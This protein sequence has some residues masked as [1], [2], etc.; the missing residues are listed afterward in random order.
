MTC[1]FLQIQ[2]NKMIGLNFHDFVLHAM[3]Y[4]CTVPV[5]WFQSSFQQPKVYLVCTV[6]S[7]KNNKR[8]LS[9][10]RWT[11]YRNLTACVYFTFFKFFIMMCKLFV[12]SFITVL[13][14]YAKTLMKAK[15]MHNTV[16]F[17]YKTNLATV[18]NIK[19]NPIDFTNDIK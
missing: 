7:F 18:R 8:L 17:S 19:H 5:L 2:Q 16:F 10:K 14:Q 9:K 3:I 13:Q 12:K 15:K 1:D 11:F 6:F 4:S